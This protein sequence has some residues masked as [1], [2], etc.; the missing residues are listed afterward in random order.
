VGAL[1]GD[2]KKTE[3]KATTRV[4]MDTLI[5]NTDAPAHLVIIKFEQ[6]IGLVEQTFAQKG[7]S[8]YLRHGFS[9]CFTEIKAVYP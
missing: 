5:T 4:F 2:K 6:I 1:F 7:G 8:L 3:K 9:D